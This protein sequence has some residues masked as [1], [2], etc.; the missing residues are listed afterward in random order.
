MAKCF[1]VTNRRLLVIIHAVVNAR[2]SKDSS[3]G[4]SLYMR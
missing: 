2:L 1:H 3:V 4:D